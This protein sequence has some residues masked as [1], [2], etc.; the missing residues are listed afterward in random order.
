[1]NPYQAVKDFEQTIAEY[2]GAKYGVAVESCT[3]ALFL[4]LK[5]LKVHWLNF[6]IKK[7]NNYI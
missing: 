1:M 6:D 3:A 4:A 2:A 5:Y 7:I